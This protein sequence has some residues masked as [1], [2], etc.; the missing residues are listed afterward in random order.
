VGPGD[1]VVDGVAALDRAGPRSLS[2][3]ASRRYAG[4]FARSRAGAVLVA[5]AF[6]GLAGRPSTRI[7]VVDPHR[8]MLEVMARLFPVP[9][10][11]GGV[12]PTARLGPGVILGAQ[13]S[14]GPHVSIGAGVRLGDR[15]RLGPGVVI[16]AGV[17][18]GDDTVVGARVVVGSGT[19]VGKRVVIKPGAVLGTTGFGYVSGPDGHDRIP[20]V[21]ACLIG[22][23][24][25]IGAN[26]CIDRGSLDDTVIGDGTKID[27]LVQIGHNVRIG[28][29]CLLMAGVGVAGSTRIGDGVVLAGQVGVAGHLTV[30]DGVRAAA[31]AGISGD[32]PAGATVT[33]FP[34]RPN[35]EFL[36]SQAVLYR[37][38]P[39]VR[40]LEALV[41]NRNSDA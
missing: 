36:R 38:V 23:D 8:A 39:I 30:G 1:I 11:V 17:E 13:V 6:E 35:R 31:Q 10:V 28:R 32:I 27:N 25:D 19:Q 21:G 34:A 3:L 4:A 33:G 26:T 7:V 15:V 22:D 2:L 18:I 40:D 16:E 14:V 37:L 5:E 20:H 9:A 24:V 12:D 29:R 41:R